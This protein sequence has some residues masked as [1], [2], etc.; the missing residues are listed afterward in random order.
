[1]V[2]RLTQAPPAPEALKTA[3]RVIQKKEGGRYGDI[4]LDIKEH[5]QVL[6]EVK[7]LVLPVLE[8]LSYP[9]KISDDKTQIF[10]HRNWAEGFVRQENLWRRNLSFAPHFNFEGQD[11]VV[12][13]M[14]KFDQE[15]NL[16]QLSFETNYKH[17]VE[18]VAWVGPVEKGQKVPA[19]VFRV[20]SYGIASSGQLEAILELAKA[21]AH[22]APRQA[23]ANGQI[24]PHWMERFNMEANL[25]GE[26]PFNEGFPRYPISGGKL[27]LYEIILRGSER[28]VAT[29]DMSTQYRAEGLRWSE[30][31]PIVHYGNRINPVIVTAW[32]QVW[33]PSLPE[34]YSKAKYPRTHQDASVNQAQV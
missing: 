19:E 17:D 6:E 23:I 13:V 10:D 34:Y 7:G 4:P 29:V 27:N 1:M 32:R 31:L 24:S 5:T 33:D 9:E 14:G 28:T 18:T 2:E 25:D 22:E 15:N 11:F 20:P 16:R 12:G 21:V 26:F 30:D 3:I 8:A